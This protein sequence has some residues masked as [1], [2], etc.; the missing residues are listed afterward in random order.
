M[1][2]AKKNDKTVLLCIDYGQLRG[3]R[4]YSKVVLC[5]GYHQLRVREPKTASRTRYG[6][7]EFT[8]ILFG[9]TNAPA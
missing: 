8:A 4:D 1:L 5:I 7:F 2:F 9:L 6:Y 3:V